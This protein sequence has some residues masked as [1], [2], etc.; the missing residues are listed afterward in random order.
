MQYNF[1]H[2]LSELLHFSA[3]VGTA[4]RL[5]SAYG[6]EFA[7]P[8][9]RPTDKVYQLKKQNFFSRIFKKPQYVSQSNPDQ[10]VFDRVVMSI[11]SSQDL[12]WITDTI[13]NFS[14]LANAI[15]SGNPEH[16]N[17]TCDHFISYFNWLMDHNQHTQKGT[18]GNPAETF[19]KD[20]FRE[21]IEIERAINAINSIKSKLL[22]KE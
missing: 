3:G 12:M 21:L 11:E 17:K 7:R 13:H 14:S 2:E 15:S 20:K 16:I 10:I 4:A 18:K 19:S 6:S 8:Q 22:I 9:A 5:F 1:T